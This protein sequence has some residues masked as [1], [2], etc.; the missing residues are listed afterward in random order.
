MQVYGN[1][2]ASHY[3]RL[4]LEYDAD[5]LTDQRLK[6]ILDP[7]KSIVVVRAR[8]GSRRN[9]PE[10]ELEANVVEQIVRAHF[11]AS[12]RNNHRVMVVTPHHRQRAAVQRRLLAQDFGGEQILVD[13]VEKM[14]GQECELVLACF[15][16][17][18]IADHR[19]DFLLDFKRWNV[20]IS[21][22][23]SVLLNHYVQKR[24]TTHIHR[25]FRCK[26]IVVTTDHVMSLSTHGSMNLFKKRKTTEGWGFICLL[27]AWALSTG[28]VVEWIDE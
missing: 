15:T 13:T 1:D 11:H 23:R 22:A 27:E 10:T 14:Q 25:L 28:S 21:R 16:F 4:R 17:A 12:K 7:N 8:S 9:E 5:R 24:N 3:P 2:L 26:V 19:I 6:S 20:A 18:D